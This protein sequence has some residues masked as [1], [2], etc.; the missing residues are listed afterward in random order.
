MRAPIL[1]F[2]MEIFIKLN[3]ELLCTYVT[4]LDEEEA[5][6]DEDE[7]WKG[8]C[9]FFCHFISRWIRRTNMPLLTT[10]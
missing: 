6:D 3:V 8:F 10:C 1:S 5:A 7:K 9:F 4:P 2:T